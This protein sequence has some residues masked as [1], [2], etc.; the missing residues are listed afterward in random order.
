MNLAGNLAQLFIYTRIIPFA[1]YPAPREPHISVL[2][3]PLDFDHC[4]DRIVVKEDDK[5]EWRM[6]G[7]EGTT[8]AG[9]LL[10]FFELVARQRPRF[11]RPHEA[12]ALQLLLRS[13]VMSYLHVLHA[14][15]PFT[16]IIQYILHP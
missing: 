4:L 6:Y 9:S 5:S 13:R 7:K 2:K 15:C 16:F 3:P 1:T 12:A 14:T 11:K 8:I 10:Q